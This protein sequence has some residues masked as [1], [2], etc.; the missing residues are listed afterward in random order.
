MVLAGMLLPAAASAQEL[1]LKTNLLSDAVTVPSLG[2]EFTIAR[3]W[4]LNTDVEW[5]PFYQSDNHYLRTCKLQ[6]EAR[7]WTA[8]R[9]PVPT[10]APRSIGECITWQACPYL[11]LKTSVFRATSML[12]ALLLDGTSH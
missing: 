8:H 10:L 7:F 11:S 6:S 4:T 1:A 12:Q 2:V 3:R 9:S 5:M